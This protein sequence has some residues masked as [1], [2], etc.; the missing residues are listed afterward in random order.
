M[1]LK[2]KIVGM[3]K[4]AI[5]TPMQTQPTP[6]TPIV[7]Q[8][9]MPMS[10]PGGSDPAMDGF[11]MMASALFCSQV[12]VHIYHLQTVGA[13][14]FA[15]HKALKRYYTG[16]QDLLDGLIESYQGKY[17]IVTGYKSMEYKDFTS[18]EDLVTYFTELEGLIEMNR[19]SIK[20][21]YLQ[22][23]VDTIVELINSTLYKLKNL[24]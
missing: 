24:Q 3:A 2:D 4:N 23:Q 1:D 15:A 19:S 18:V 20:E 6:E 21:S 12:Q 7:G 13:S 14:S 10:V 5:P 17:S 22:N 11:K 8:P 9:G 16:I